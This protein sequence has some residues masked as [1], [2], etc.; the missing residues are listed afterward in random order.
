MAAVFGGL[1]QPK[2]FLQL[3]VDNR[4]FARP[5]DARVAAAG[6]REPLRRELVQVC[7]LRPRQQALQRRVHVDLGNRRAVGNLS[8]FWREPHREILCL[9]VGPGLAVEIVQVAQTVAQ[10][11]RLLGEVEIVHNDTGSERVGRRLSRDLDRSGGELDGSGTL[12]IPAADFPSVELCDD[13]LCDADRVEGF[14]LLDTCRRADDG[15]A[16]VRQGDLRDGEPRGAEERRVA[17]FRACAAGQEILVV[18]HVLGDLLGEGCGDDGARRGRSLVLDE[19]LEALCFPLGCAQLSDVPSRVVAHDRHRRRR[20]ASQLE[21]RRAQ[22]RVCGQ[23]GELLAERGHGPCGPRTEC[24]E[25][26]VG[27]G[28]R[29]LRWRI[30]ERE[31]RARAPRVHEEC[32]LREIGRQDFGR[33]VRAEVLVVLRGITANDVA[34]SL[35]ART[36]GALIGARLRRGD[37]HQSGHA[38]LRVAPGHAR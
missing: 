35:A 25:G 28:K 37:R 34:R 7:R 4:A 8:Q 33:D 12:D 11:L 6:H 2:A 23:D 21:Q 9:E 30:E 22:P 26:A 17:D 10:E 31:V 20:A 1:R 38:A 15:V 18:L 36:A 14:G 24:F 13:L 3:D 27:I 19:L 29:G 32:G 5:V 16:S